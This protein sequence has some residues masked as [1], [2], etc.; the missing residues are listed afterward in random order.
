M[1][2]EW[3]PAADDE[4]YG[5]RDRDTGEVE[6]EATRVDLVFGS[7]AQLRLIAEVYAAEDGEEKFVQDFVDAWHKV[8]TLDRFDLE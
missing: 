7:N 3:E 6:W 2:T 4:V 5:G 8:M 1:D